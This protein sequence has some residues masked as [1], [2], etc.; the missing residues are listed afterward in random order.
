MRK[1]RDVAG[2]STLSGIVEW[3]VSLGLISGAAFLAVIGQ[4]IIALALIALAIGVFLRLKR[5]SK[6]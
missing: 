3:A 2:L 1:N 5:R 4:S 6:R